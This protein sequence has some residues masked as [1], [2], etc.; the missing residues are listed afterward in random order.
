[1]RLNVF[2]TG[3]LVFAVCSLFADATAARQ[4]LM[5]AADRALEQ[6]PVSVMDKKKVPPS[7]D[8]HDYLSQAPYWWPDPAKPDGKPYIRKDGQR[9]PEIDAIAD[10]DNLGRLGDAVATLGLAYAY[11]GREVYAAHAARLVR[12]WFLDPATRMNP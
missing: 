1:M 4:A 3:G 9:N 6:K 11:T 5:Q 7:G 2:L 12:A 8:K 10:H